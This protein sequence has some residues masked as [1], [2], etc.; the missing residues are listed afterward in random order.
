MYPG[1]KNMVNLFGLKSLMK[2]PTLPPANLA[3]AGDDEMSN[4]PLVIFRDQHMTIPGAVVPKA[5]QL[6]FED[7]AEKGANMTISLDNFA[8]DDFDLGYV[9][10][11]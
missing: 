3:V 8:T 1:Y 9:Y 5:S 10:N 11:T 4:V 7:V 6:A 2:A